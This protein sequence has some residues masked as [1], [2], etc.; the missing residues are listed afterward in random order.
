MKRMIRRRP[1]T[2]GPISGSTAPSVGGLLFCKNKA[3][4]I[5][6]IRQDRILQYKNGKAQKVRTAFLF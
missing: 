6:A 1:E 4:G 2:F 3:S 5:I